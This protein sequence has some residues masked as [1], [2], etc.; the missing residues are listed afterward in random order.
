[1]QND[2]TT[3]L[4]SLSLSRKKSMSKLLCV[5]FCRHGRSSVFQL[6]LCYKLNNNK[7]RSTFYISYY[8]K[9]SINIWFPSMA[10][11]WRAIFVSVGVLWWTVMSWCTQ[12]FSTIGNIG[13]LLGI[14]RVNWMALFGCRELIYMIC[15]V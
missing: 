2:F 5:C 11:I 3:V 10:R 12:L 6:F 8:P 15:N 9:Q 7:K 14:Y 1:M 13:L 4:F